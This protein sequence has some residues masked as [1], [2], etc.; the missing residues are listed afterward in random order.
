MISHG[1]L[2]FGYK[3]DITNEFE[4]L[5]KLNLNDERASS[6]KVSAEFHHII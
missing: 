2:G 1:Y 3:F 5:T 4:N 6:A